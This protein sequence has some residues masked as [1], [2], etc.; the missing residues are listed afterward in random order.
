MRSQ[1]DPNVDDDLEDELSEEL[2]TGGSNAPTPPPD[3]DAAGGDPDDIIIDQ[4]LET[5]DAE[6][7][8]HSQY[9]DLGG[10]KVR[11]I[12]FNVV[13]LQYYLLDRLDP[14]F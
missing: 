5:N 6:T 7:T 12:R 3:K 4:A 14:H 2:A 8:K 13:Q 9:L 1:S 10:T 11:P